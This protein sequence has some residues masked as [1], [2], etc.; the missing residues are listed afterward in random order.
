[1]LLRKGAGGWVPT[2]ALAAALTTAEGRV[3]KSGSTLKLYLQSAARI[4]GVRTW[5]RRA[6][7]KYL[8][9]STPA[10]SPSGAG[11]MQEERRRKEEELGVYRAIS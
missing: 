5:R 3:L 1:V 10:L 8:T 4:G 6:L 2:G 11:S 9:A 7:G